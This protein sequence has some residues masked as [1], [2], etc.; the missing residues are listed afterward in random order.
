[1][2]KVWGVGLEVDEG[3]WMSEAL[4]STLGVLAGREIFK[5]TKLCCSIKYCWMEDFPAHMPVDLF[6]SICFVSRVVC[7]LLTAAYSNEHLVE[8]SCKSPR[9]SWLRTIRRRR[10]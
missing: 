4:F 9:S 3:T 5:G 8:S 1:M 6:I 2:V 10:V 7:V